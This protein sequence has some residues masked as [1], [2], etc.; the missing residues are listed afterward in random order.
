SL[1]GGPAESGGAVAT[2]SAGTS[3][4][5]SG[6]DAGAAMGFGADG[7][8]TVVADL[9]QIAATAL[10]LPTDPLFP[11]Q[12]YLHGALASMS[13]RCGIIIRAPA[14]RLPSSTRASIAS[15]SISTE[16]SQSRSA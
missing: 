10:P 16:I 7:S 4:G 1:F 11:A 5:S 3:S 6:G 9:S 12:W 13:S 15:T 8:E 14:S 2:S